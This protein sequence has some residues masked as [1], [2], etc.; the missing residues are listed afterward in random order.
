MDFF[1]PRSGPRQAWV[2]GA[3]EACPGGQPAVS[4]ADAMMPRGPGF[5]P[6]SAQRDGRAG[7]SGTDDARIRV[8]R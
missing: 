1:T 4:W 3:S 8:L 6:S 7:H 2:D 5:Q